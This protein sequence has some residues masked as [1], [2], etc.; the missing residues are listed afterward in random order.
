MQGLEVDSFFFELLSDLIKSFSP[1]TK[2]DRLEWL[3]TTVMSS[4]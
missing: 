3:I 2:D 4:P 1:L